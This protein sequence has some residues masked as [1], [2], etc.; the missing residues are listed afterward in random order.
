MRVLAMPN[1]I[2]SI[3][4]HTVR[5]L[6]EI[7]LDARGL[8]L[9][10]ALVASPEG[11]EVLTFGRRFSPTWVRRQLAARYRVVKAIR[12]A[13]VIHW[14]N[15]APRSLRGLGIDVFRRFGKPGVVEWMGI[16]IRIPELELAENAY[17]AAAWNAGYEHR[18]IESRKHSRERQRRFARLGFASVTPPGMVQYV[19][20]D[21]FAHTHVVPQRLVLADYTPRYPD[22]EARPVTIAHSSTAPVAKG[23]A[24]VVRAIEHLRDR[25]PLRF[26]LIQGIRRDRALELVAESDIFVD[27]LVLGDYGMAALEAL[28]LGKPVVCYLKPSLAALYGPELPI[29]NAT[30][31]TLPDVL[32]ALIRNGARRRALGRQ[33]RAH[34]ER[35]HD[36][37]R[38]AQQLKTIYETVIARQAP[39]KT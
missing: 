14:C 35:H 1:N 16:D 13:D 23:T 37:R 28:A 8:V 19:Q 5:G 7:G 30:Q 27:Q 12:W 36:A 21:I 32:E 3:L 20:R 9:G 39:G 31:D 18:W 15:V 17:Y 29:V 34:V 26:H 2:S 10:N 4:S 25:Y 11:L 22:P 6:R 24:A 33:G 38:I